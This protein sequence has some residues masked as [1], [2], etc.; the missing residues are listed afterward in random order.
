[1]SSDCFHNPVYLLT[2]DDI[3]SQENLDVPEAGGW[4][5]TL[6]TEDEDEFFD[7][8]IV[9]HYDG[10]VGMCLNHQQ[11]PSGLWEI[12]SAAWSYLLKQRIV[13]LYR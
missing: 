13:F 11:H 3:S 2:A 12:L 7:L 9:K 4:D 6:S 8:Q 10:E 1:M 5:A